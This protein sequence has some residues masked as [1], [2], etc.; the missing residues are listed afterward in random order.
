MDIKLVGLI[1]CGE[2]LPQ[3]KKTDRQ[4]RPT[5]AILR[6]TYAK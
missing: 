1:K 6:P 3:R 5:R 2:I 4:A